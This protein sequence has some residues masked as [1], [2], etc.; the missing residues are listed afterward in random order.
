[1]LGLICGVLQAA[2]C[3]AVVEAQTGA[4]QLGTRETI[5]ARMGLEVIAQNGPCGRLT[6]SFPLPMD[7]PEQKILTERQEATKNVS[8]VR[9]VTIDDGVRQ[10]KFHVAPMR[11]GESAQLVFELKIA[12]AALR[13]PEDPALLALAATKDRELRRFLGPSPFIETG[14]RDV[15]RAADALQLP[16]DKPAWQ[17]VQAIRD[18]MEAKIKYSGVKALKGARRAL[19]DG[20]GDCEERT[21]VFVALCRLKGIPARSVWIPQHAYAEFYLETP[22][23]KGFWYPC[24]SVGGTFGEMGADF[25]ILQK[26]DSFL[27]PVKGK[28]QRYIT[29]TAKG[30]AR[31]GEVAPVLRPIQEFRVLGVR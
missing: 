17:Q 26:G 4:P 28:R 6:C 1:M 30:N 29:E 14:H 19:A 27:D 13:T 3:P 25:V 11:R 15:K 5:H 12:R 18:F 24:E 2:S 7:W 31:R 10:A 16:N 8:R 21:S 9:I 23:G 22:A 20:D